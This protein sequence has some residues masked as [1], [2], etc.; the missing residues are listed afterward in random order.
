[1]G[2]VED[3]ST[4]GVDHASGEPDEHLQPSCGQRDGHTFG[5]RWSKPIEV[6]RKPASEQGAADNVKGD[7]RH[8]LTEQD[9]SRRLR[10]LESVE[11]PGGGIDHRRDQTVDL[12][13]TEDRLDQTALLFPGLALTG[14]KALTRHDGKQ[15][16]VRGLLKRVVAGDEH[17][18][19]VAR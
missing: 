2:R 6:L 19:D 13:A 15:P 10:R 9:L 16:I 3:R 4:A 18:L 8:F 17:L 12:A 5:H 14:E 1:M 11:V 7:C